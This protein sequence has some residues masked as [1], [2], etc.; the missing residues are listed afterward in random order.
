[1][2]NNNGGQAFPKS[3]AYLNPEIG[4]AELRSENGMSLRDWFAGQAL[5]GI[6]TNQIERQIIDCN[7]IAGIAYNFA[8]AMLK[9]REKELK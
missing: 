7:I 2:A 1:M 9:E 4:R 8:D 6:V 5:V 3:Y